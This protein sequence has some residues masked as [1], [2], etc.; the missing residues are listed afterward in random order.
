MAREDIGMGGHLRGNV[1][2]NLQEVDD[3]STSAPPV[4]ELTARSLFSF[5]PPDEGAHTHMPALSSTAEHHGQDMSVSS[6]QRIIRDSVALTSSTSSAPG[7]T[8]SQYLEAGSE[9]SSIFGLGAQD[10]DLND[11]ELDAHSKEPSSVSAPKPVRPPRAPGEPAYHGGLDAPAKKGI[12]AGEGYRVMGGT[13]SASPHHVIRSPFED[14]TWQHPGLGN[15]VGSIRSNSAQ[16][17][18]V[19]GAVVGR[20]SLRVAVDENG[21]V[22]EEGGGDDGYGY[23]Q[24]R[25]DE[26]EAQL[27]FNMQHL[28]LPPGMHRPDSA[29]SRPS[30][31]GSGMQQ[32]MTPSML[33]PISPATHPMQHHGFMPGDLPGMYSRDDMGQGAQQQHQMNAQQ[34]E[35][36]RWMMAQGQG[37]AEGGGMNMPGMDGMHAQGM[38]GGGMPGAGGMG[39]GGMGAGQMSD[40]MAQMQAMAPAAYAQET[41]LPCTLNPEP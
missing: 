38:G 19:G 16:G 9:I 6:E 15:V 26:D 12:L 20:S 2:A 21:E 1:Y 7:Q 18:A 24:R 13:R 25:G 35:M 23:G 3:R 8:G 39:N 28:T 29:G 34:A 17:G 40:M 14:G 36:Q 27:S 11:P 33:Q 4:L 37:Q 30:Q 5:R 41:R 10:F 32:P 31:P 22:K